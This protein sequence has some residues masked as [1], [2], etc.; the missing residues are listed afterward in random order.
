MGIVERHSPGG[1]FQHRPL[2]PIHVTALYRQAAW[3]D[4]Q[5][6][7]QPWGLGGQRDRDDHA[8]Q[9]R[10]GGGPTVQGRYRGDP[11]VQGRVGGGPAVQERYRG[12]M[13]NLVDQL[14]VRLFQV[15]PK[16]DMRGVAQ[17]LWSMGKMG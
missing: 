15:L 1:V 5:Q 6:Q 17:A 9:G 13:D 16:M 7:Q 8:V 3:L 4:R 14:N 12:G 10:D 11:E 2:G